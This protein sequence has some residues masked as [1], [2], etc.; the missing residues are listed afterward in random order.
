MFGKRIRFKFL[1]SLGE[2]L[3]RLKLLVE[4]EHLYFFTA[5]DQYQ[6]NLLDDKENVIEATKKFMNGTQLSIFEKVLTYLESNNANFDYIGSDN[7]K[8]LKNVAASTAP[9]KGSLMQEAKEALDNIQAEL[10][11]KQQTERLAAKESIQSSIAKLKQFNDFTKLDE[12]QQAEIIAPLERSIKEIEQERFIGNI[13]SKAYNTN[14]DVYQ[15]QLEKMLSLA[16][17]PL[18]TPKTALGVVGE[19]TPPV[20][21]TPKITFVRKDSV[22]INFKKPALETKQDV[23]DYLTALREQY[24][25]IIDEDKR[26]SL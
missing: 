5:L 12:K 1:E 19:P 24:F 23:E 9:Y 17:P 25:R 4:K 26:I 15:R 11:E 6:D 22:K 18:P 21:S 8:A 7:I 13:R 10:S 16:N 20:Y 3:N 14:I 2:P